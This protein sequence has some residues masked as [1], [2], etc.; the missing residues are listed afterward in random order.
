M[1]RIAPLLLFYL[2]LNVAGAAQNTVTVRQSLGI[3]YA[4]TDIAAD[5]IMGQMMFAKVRLYMYGDDQY[6]MIRK[7]ANTTEKTLDAL[8]MEII[9]QL[10]TGETWMCI[11]VGV[12]K[13]RTGEGASD[14]WANLGFDGFQDTAYVFSKDAA[15]AQ[16]IQ[17]YACENWK[18]SSDAL[19]P[20]SLYVS[21]D[22][23]ASPILEKWPFYLKKDANTA[24]ICLG[25]DKVFGNTYKMRAQKVEIDK[26]TDL[27]AY[28]QGFTV[29]QGEEFNTAIKAYLGF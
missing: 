4:F 12:K 6:V 11:T 14:L 18:F 2:L 9:T 7:Y 16:Q 10:S 20:V 21:S 25:S 29:V 23:A 22:F 19:T 15:Q 1:P 27:G 24:G 3:E 17:G 13:M 26:K 8:P 28:L 5:D